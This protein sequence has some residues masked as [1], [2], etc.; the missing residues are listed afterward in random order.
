MS[1]LLL[2]FPLKPH[3]VSDDLESFVHVLMD[4]TLRHFKHDLSP[5]KPPKSSSGAGATRDND[6][7]KH[8]TQ[9]KD[10][11]LLPFKDTLNE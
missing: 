4:Q 7:D 6:A 5:P 9:G 3:G 2:N 11:Q 1:S 10:E 8:T